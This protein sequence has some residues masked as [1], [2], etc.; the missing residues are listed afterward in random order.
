MK[1]EIKKW[2]NDEVL[3]SLDIENNSIKLTVEAAVKAGV[4]LSY[5]NLY[6]AN[7]VRAN[8]VRAN[9]V[10]ANLYSANLY[11]AN[12]YSANLY[13][14]NLVR[15]NLYSANLDSA[16]LDSANLVRANLVRANLDSANLYSANLDSANLNGAKY[17]DFTIKKL[18]IQISNIG[19]YVL[20][21]ET[22][23]KIGC[24]L[25]THD[26]WKN[27]TNREIAEMDGK[28]ALA[29]WKQYKSLLVGF[30]KTMEEKKIKKKES[31]NE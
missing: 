19:Y 8:L 6:S 28:K 22:H 4:S 11:S 15:A 5:A 1:I 17:G 30:C 26:E 25:H 2:T 21:F 12:L 20:I 14:A 24:E 18:P 3:F 16:N 10:R 23:M 29:F 7:L 31:N 9:L 13:S 27:F